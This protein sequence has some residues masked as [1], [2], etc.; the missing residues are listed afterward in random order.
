MLK[1]FDKLYAWCSTFVHLNSL[2]ATD[3]PQ[4]VPKIDMQQCVHANY[5]RKTLAIV[6]HVRLDFSIT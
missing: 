3:M 5:C 2:G 1:A 4:F 6:G